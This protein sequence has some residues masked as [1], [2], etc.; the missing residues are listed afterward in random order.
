MNMVSGMTK[1]Q[2]F[3]H[4]LR[5]D[6]QWYIENFLKIRDKRAL[7]IPFTLNNAQN[8]VLRIM[9]QDERG[10]K[11]KRYIVLKARQMGLSTLFEGLI[12]HDTSTHENKNSLI[13]AHEEQASSNLF[14]MSKLYYENI[15]EVIRPMKKYANGKNLVFENPTADEN[16]KLN[17]PGLRSK[18]SIA[19]AGAGEVGR[20]ATYHNIHASEV[21]FFPDAKTT[22]LGL[23]QAVPDQPNT[24]V[25]MESTANGVGDW[26]HEMWVKAERGENEFTPIFLPWFIQPEYTRSF[27]SDAEKL[28]LIEEVSAISKDM[29]GNEVRTYEY[30]LKE[31]HG[32]TWEQLNWRRYTMANKCQ[33][34]EIL[35]MQ[36][37]P[38]TPEEAFIS[39]G[40]P[41]FSIK[42]LKKY[43]T[44]T[45]EP[46]ARGYLHEKEGKVDFVEDS[47]GYVSIW[48]NPVPDMFY[49][50]GADVAEGLAHGDYSTA[51][52][53]DSDFDVVA[54]WHGH[55]DPDLFG[56]ELVKL[57]KYYNDAYLG[58]ENNNH[59]LTTLTTIK[60]M[61][62]W[63]LFFSKSYDKI[64]DQITQKLGWQTTIRTKPLMIDKLAEFVREHYIGI[65][66]DLIISEM[67]T[68]VIED[69]GKT[70]AQPGTHDDTVMAL[71]ILLQLL[72]E[73]KGEFYV[74]EIPIDQ[75]GKARVTDTV[76]PLFELEQDDE[77]SD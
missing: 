61:E 25:V 75:R 10:N 30:E 67:F 27:R 26:F 74:P 36:E 77:F 56:V 59:G 6:K 47:N 42:S 58:V 52:V 57:A 40:R 23:L 53:G 46:I 24:M 9:E 60:K 54:M 55:I 44:I 33:G 17:N 12:F 13:I 38:S 19:T 7:I 18:I 43:Q 49:A 2:L 14:N 8:R 11:P 34:D 51:M 3:Y 73:G 35:F 50:I 69:N 66:S 63:N 76:D 22:M 5:N 41:K 20:S 68:Y 37:Y 64:A 62:Y 4:K 31:K 48:R 1:E 45:K 16:E 39:S 21:A 71:A 72:L 32:L 29:Q 28:Q 70:N 15:P 65:Y